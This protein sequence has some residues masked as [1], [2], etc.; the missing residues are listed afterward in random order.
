M[1]AKE[2]NKANSD[3]N[4]NFLDTWKMQNAKCSTCVF[5]WHFTPKL[6]GKIY[7]LTFKPT[8]ITIKLEGIFLFWLHAS[9]KTFFFKTDTHLGHKLLTWLT[10]D[11]MTIIYLFKN[12]AYFT[13]LEFLAAPCPNIPKLKCGRVRTQAHE[14][15]Q[16][17]KSTEDTHLSNFEFLHYTQILHCLK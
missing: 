3:K 1:F 5:I 13:V 10:G 15:P 11:H 17:Y 8:P 14:Y 2:I 7:Y 12:A 6:I 16:H 4:I 9:Y